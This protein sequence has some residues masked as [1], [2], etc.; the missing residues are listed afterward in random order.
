[1]TFPSP[2][3]IYLFV[4][5]NLEMVLFFKYILNLNEF[6]LTLEPTMTKTNYFV[7]LAVGIFEMETLVLNVES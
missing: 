3:V 1:M 6:K 4:L 2:K 7:C 5:F